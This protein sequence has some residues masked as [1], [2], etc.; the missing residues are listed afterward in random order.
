MSLVCVVAPQ[1]PSVL[2]DLRFLQKSWGKAKFSS[3]CWTVAA[4][5][6][7]LDATLGSVDVDARLGAAALGVRLGAAVLG[8]RLGAAVLG[9]RL[10]A[11]VLGVRLGAALS[12]PSAA[13]LAASSSASVAPTTLP[14]NAGSELSASRPIICNNECA[15]AVAKPT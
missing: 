9:A 15:M 14:S 12:A 10:G 1:N 3:N 5:T 4:S 13:H 7:D 6:A 2:H 11:A 8:A